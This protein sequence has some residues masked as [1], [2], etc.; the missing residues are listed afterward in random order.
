MDTVVQV[1]CLAIVRV[2]QVAYVGLH[3]GELSLKL[4]DLGV[5]CQDLALELFDCLLTL[6]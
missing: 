2:T 3:L 6:P 4:V 1:L 5:L